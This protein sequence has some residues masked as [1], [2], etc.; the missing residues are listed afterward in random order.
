ME[1][2]RDSKGR[3]LK[4]GESQRKDG[5]YAYK[6]TDINGTP[7]FVYSWKLTPTDKIPAGKRPGISLREKEKEIQRDLQDG[8]GTAGKTMTVCQLYAKQNSHRQDVRI[9]T[10]KNRRCLMTVLGR[11]LLGAKSIDSVKPSDAKEWAVRMYKKGYAYRTI[12][13]YKRSL[14]AAFGLAV[15]DDIIR[16]NPFNFALDTVIKDNTEPKKALT[17]E[18]AESL[19]AFARNNTIYQ[20]YADAIV[21]LLGTGLRISELCGLTVSDID[22][23]KRFIS[24]NHQLLKD[25]AHGY[26]INMPKTKSGVRQIPMSQKVFEA[27]ERSVADRP[28]QSDFEVDGYRDF[29][30]LNRNGTPKT[31]CD[32]N[33]MLSRLVNKYNRQCVQELPNVTP[34]TLRHTFCTHMANNGMNPKAL[35]YLMG[36][37]N[38]SMTL[39]YYTHADFDSAKAEMERLTA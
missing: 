8:I 25:V 6:Y 26:Y 13:N 15:E 4:N 7:R 10:E 12:N 38:I 20:K 22:F 34:H 16:K 32:Y 3:T 18:Q 29:L 11:D 35:Q 17:A 31:S 30:F 14:K 33:G 23:E 9:N 24:I 39:D 21:I 36:H 5:R 27:L 1:K 19:V 2:R 37:S 28:A